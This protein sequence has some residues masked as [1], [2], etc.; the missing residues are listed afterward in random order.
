MVAAP[1]VEQ[2][3]D[4]VV[5][6]ALDEPGHG[7]A[8]GDVLTAISSDDSTSGR[9]CGR[10]RSL[11]RS[12]LRD[13]EETGQPAGDLLDVFDVRRRATRRP[14]RRPSGRGRR[15][16]RCRGPRRVRR[17]SC[18]RSPP[19]S[20]VLGLLAQHGAVAG[21]GVEQVVVGA[22]GDEAAARRGG[23]AR[24]ASATVDGRCTTT[25]TVHSASTGRSAACDDR[26]GV[27]VERRERV[28]EHQHAR[29]AD[30]GA[31][32]REAL[33]LA[34][35]RATGPA[36]RCGCR[37]PTAGRARSR[38]ARPRGPSAPRPRSRRACPSAG[39]RARSPRTASAPRTRSRRAAAGW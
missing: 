18:A 37:G 21:L 20:T 31:G 19:R 2:R 4:A 33:A 15:R 27:H 10:M 17:R 23:S 11:S 22:D 1:A 8:G 12:R 35:R 6:A 36:R 14:A 26:L 3:R 5:D 32:Q 34:A 25:S 29:P 28:V 39:S 30:D 9:W 38:P 7:Q 24:S 13:A 16:D